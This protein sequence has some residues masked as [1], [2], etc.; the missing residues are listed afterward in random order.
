MGEV[1]PT[2]KRK[3]IAN[4]IVIVWAVAGLAGTLVAVVLKVLHRH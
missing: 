2:P 3:T 4:W 1:N